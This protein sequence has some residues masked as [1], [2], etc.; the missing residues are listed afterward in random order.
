MGKEIKNSKEVDKFVK[1]GIDL[2]YTFTFI[3]GYVE[4]EGRINIGVKCNESGET[5]YYE[6]E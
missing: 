5:M 1:S 2:G 6:Y 3:K 4:G